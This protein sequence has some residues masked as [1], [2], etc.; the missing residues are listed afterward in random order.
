MNMSEIADVLEDP[1]RYGGVSVA[2]GP[3]RVP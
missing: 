3:V 2:A 1:A